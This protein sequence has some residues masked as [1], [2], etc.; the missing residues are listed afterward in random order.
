MLSFATVVLAFAINQE[1]ERLQPVL[2]AFLL[3]S[4]STY[5]SLKTFIY[6]TILQTLKL[7]SIQYERSSLTPSNFLFISILYCPD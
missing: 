6:G 1:V 5:F 7:H 3:F 2:D 4:N